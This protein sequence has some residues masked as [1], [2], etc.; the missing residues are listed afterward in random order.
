MHPMGT[1]KIDE[2]GPIPPYA[3]P[4]LPTPIQ[5]HGMQVSRQEKNASGAGDYG[6]VL[7][8]TPHQAEKSVPSA[9]WAAPYHGVPGVGGAVAAAPLPQLKME[10]GL[11]PEQVVQG[12]HYAVLAQPPVS[13]AANP[14]YPSCSLP[15]PMGFAGFPT[16][17]PTNPNPTPVN[18]SAVGATHLG[19]GNTSGAPLIQNQLVAPYY[20]MANSFLASTHP[21]P[22]PFSGKKGDWG[23]WKRRWIL[24]VGVLNAVGCGVP[25]AFLLSRLENCL[26]PPTRSEVRAWSEGGSN[27]SEIWGKLCAYFEKDQEETTRV[28]WENLTL[29]FRGKLSSAEWRHFA[30]QF[31]VLMRRTPGAT[32]N[33]GLRLLR[34][35]LP[36]FLAEKLENEKA[37]RGK[38]GDKALGIGG[39]SIFAGD[40]A[41]YA[42]VQ[43]VTGQPPERISREGWMFWVY[44]QNETQRRLILELNGRKLEDGTTVSICQRDPPMDVGTAIQLVSN[45]I[46]MK[47]MVEEAKSLRPPVSQ[48]SRDTRNVVPQQNTPVGG[49]K[50]PTRTPSAGYSPRNSP[51]GGQFSSSTGGGKGGGRQRGKAWNNYRSGGGRGVSQPSGG[52]Q[53]TPQT[54]N[55]QGRNTQEK[56]VPKAK[57]ATQVAGAG[58]GT[59]QGGK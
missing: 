59:P 46:G 19:G 24:H 2:K 37:K 13:M 14:S 50:S 47:E 17:T 21:P 40:A 48:K 28:A 42:W 4:P 35:Q 25:D 22:D 6:F 53:Q 5:T 44:P 32:E 36:T 9:E 18:I 39:L 56:I 57:P 23:D 10:P 16:P 27:Y 31:V 33:D 26:D 55:T 38:S 1:G 34:R 41:A 29:S 43:T 30:A 8:R 12:Q 20:G 15:L 45:W 3:Y 11:S 7:S 58:G 49:P 54:Q 51:R 52:S